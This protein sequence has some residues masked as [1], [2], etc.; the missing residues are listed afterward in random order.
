LHKRRISLEHF[1]KKHRLILI[2]LFQVFDNLL[3]GDLTPGRGSLFSNLTGFSYYFNYLLTEQPADMAYYPA[4]LEQASTRRA[5]HV[6]NLSYADSAEEVEKH[7]LK[8]MMQSVTPL[9]QV[10]RLY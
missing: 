2:Q 4:Y 1:E 3:N 6:G 7:L 8:D 5:L 9:V 10:T